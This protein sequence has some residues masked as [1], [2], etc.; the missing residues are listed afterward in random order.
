M[1]LT[2]ARECP[3]C[4]GEGDVCGECGLFLLDCECPN[5][6]AALCPDCGG[7]GTT[8]A[9]CDCHTR[10][11]CCE[12]L[13]AEVARLRFEIDHV[14]LDRAQWSREARDWQAEVERLRGV[15]RSTHGTYCTA[16]WTERGLHAPECLL[17][18][19]EAND[20]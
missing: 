2:E 7:T 11:G 16:D 18:E 6:I 10:G 5:C 19:L 14:E 8:D 3:T 17:H 4:H 9:E 1:T 12:R 13:E 20:E 15:L